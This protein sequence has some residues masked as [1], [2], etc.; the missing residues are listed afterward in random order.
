VSSLPAL[1]WGHKWRTPSGLLMIIGRGVNCH[2][3]PAGDQDRAA[4][5]DRYLGFPRIVLA[6]FCRHVMISRLNPTPAADGWAYAL[7]LHGV[8]VAD[9]DEAFS[10]NPRHEGRAEGVGDHQGQLVPPVHIVE[11]TS[12]DSHGIPMISDL[13]RPQRV[14]RQQAAH[15][16]VSA[17]SRKRSNSS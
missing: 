9:S 4:A 11:G 6:A 14:S 13:R 12:T 17:T 1:A 10:P 15:S 3:G 5:Y 2:R 16:W 8:A 7:S